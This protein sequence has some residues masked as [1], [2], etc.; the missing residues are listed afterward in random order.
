MPGGIVFSDSSSWPRF[1]RRPSKVSSRSSSG[2]DERDALGVD[3]PDEG[4]LSD[5]VLLST[6]LS[7][8]PDVPE[9]TEDCWDCEFVARAL[10]DRRGEGGAIEE[11]QRGRVGTE[12]GEEVEGA[13]YEAREG[14]ILIRVPQ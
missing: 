6:F 4:L 10:E 1:R 3:L 5:R 8:R 14:C 12:G 11:G 13:R 2:S 7:G 9:E